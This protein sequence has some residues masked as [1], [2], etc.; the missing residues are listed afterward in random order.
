MRELRSV[1][2]V[3]ALA[4][5]AAC[6]LDTGPN[7]PAPIDPAKDTYASSLG[8]D[9]ASMTKTSTGLYYKDLLA[10]VGTAAKAGDSVQVH[11]TLWLTNGT[12]VQSSRDGAGP[13]RVLLGDNSQNGAIPGFQEGIVGMLPGGKRQLVIPPQLAWGSQGNPPVQPNANIVFEVEYVSRI[14][15]G[16]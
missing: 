10:G 14:T 3:A 5:L 6:D 11:F 13:I 1:A 12:K 16:S 2:A 7:V 9:I 8:V 4:L 15:T